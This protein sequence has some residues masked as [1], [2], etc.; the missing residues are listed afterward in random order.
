MKPPI[1]L[2][3]NARSGSTLVQRILNTYPDITIWGEHGGCLRLA[4]EQYFALL[5]D[6]GNQRNIFATRP[7][8]SALSAE[9]VLKEK[10]PK[11]WQA[12]MNWFSPGDVKEIFRSHVCSLFRPPWMD[13]NNT[14]GFKEIR[15]G[16]DDRVIEFLAQL[17]PDAIFI[18]LVRNGFDQLASSLKTFHSRG[19]KTFLLSRFVPRPSLVKRCWRW[20]ARYRTYKHWH[21]SGKLN[22]FWISFE[23]LISGKPVLEPVLAAAGKSFGDEQRQTLTMPEGRGSS[24][25]D[26]SNIDSRGQLF[27]FLPLALADCILGNVNDDLGYSSPPGIKWLSLVRRNLRRVKHTPEN[28]RTLKNDAS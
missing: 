17:F 23:D 22:S 11:N 12:W 25:A 4:A 10:D 21:E 15:Y 16:L 9:Q 28:H 19:A 14:W 8:Q 2:L 13:E 7:D 26:D 1:F 24:F 5:E 3:S 20:A 27:G 6:P 18:F